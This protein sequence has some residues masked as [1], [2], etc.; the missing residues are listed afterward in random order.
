MHMNVLIIRE[1]EVKNVFMMLDGLF[2][3]FQISFHHHKYFHDL[4]FLL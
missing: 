1:N 3:A 2:G 4:K